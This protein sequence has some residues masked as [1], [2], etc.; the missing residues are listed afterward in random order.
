MGKAL[1]GPPRHSPCS[2]KY[3]HISL[4]RILELGEAAAPW[5]SQLSLVGSLN[6]PQL[7]TRLHS[8]LGPQAAD[9]APTEGRA[10]SNWMALA[11]VAPA[12]EEAAVTQALTQGPAW[13]GTGWEPRDCRGLPPTCPTSSFTGIGALRRQELVLSILQMRRL[14]AGEVKR[15]AHLRSSGW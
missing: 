11:K 12:L 2:R 5:N 14:R 10:L 3:L 9:A 8:S 13:V 6:F 1:E 7:M 15:P 4:R